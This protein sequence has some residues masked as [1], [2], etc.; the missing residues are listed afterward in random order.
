MPT[1]T[2]NPTVELLN[3]EDLLEYA[4]NNLDYAGQT[5]LLN[6]ISAELR[7]NPYVAGS[8]TTQEAW[9]N[10][11]AKKLESAGYEITYNGNGAW[12]GSVFSTKPTVTTMP[13]PIDSNVSTVSRG[14]LRNKYGG[15][16]EFGTVGQQ[17][18]VPTRFPV[19][20]GLGSKALYLVG[21]VGSGISAAS[22]GI[23]LGKTIDSALYNAFPDFWDSVGMS[24]LNPETWNS[25]TNGDDSPFAGLFN[26]ILGLDPDTGNAEAYMNE[27]TLAY[28]A[29]Y[30]KTQGVFA[31]SATSEMIDSEVDGITVNAPIPFID[32][33]TPSLV[34]INSNTQQYC[35][36]VPVGIRISTGAPVYFCCGVNERSR[37][38]SKL[39]MLRL[40]DANNTGLFAFE[41]NL[42][43]SFTA[44]LRYLDPNTG[45]YATLAGSTMTGVRT[46]N[47]K[48]I[49]ASNSLIGLTTVAY[50]Y[51][52]IMPTQPSTLRN[53]EI[54]YAALFGNYRTTGGG[55][56]GIGNQDGATLPDV[57]SW[58]DIPSTLQS[59]Q[60][61]YPDSF[62][63]PMIWNNDSPYDDTTGNMLRY[64][65]V[66]FPAIDANGNPVSDTQ[67]QT[68]TEISPQTTTQNILD[69]LMKVMQ[70]TATDTSPDDS[71][72]PQNPTDTGTGDSPTPTIP[73]GSASA[74]WSVYHPTQA[75][76]NSFGAWLWG[77]PF[78][79]DIGKLFQNPIDGVISLHKIY[80]TPVDAGS[81][82]I[83][84]GTL[85]S[86]VP[87]ATVTQ[88]YVTVN[89]GS[90]DC[91]EEFG[92]VFDYPPHTKVSLYL[93][94]IG[95]VDLDTNDVMRSTINVTYG[96]DVFTG[97][98]L[99]M[100]E[101]TRDGNTVNLYQYAGVCAVSYPLGNVQQSQLF[102]GLLA[103]AG[104]V[105]AS[106]A[107]GGVAAPAALAV[108]GGVGA[109]AKSSIGRS[110]G[111][112]GNAGA[113]GI[114]K[115]YL[116]L[117]KPQTKVA[118][119]FPRLSGYPTNKSGKLSDFS[120]Q[121]NVKSVHVEGINAT[122][123]EL[124]E[125]EA[126]LKSGVLV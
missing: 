31:T 47:D 114:K 8:L 23:W 5:E 105:A 32:L 97:A 9:A 4:A 125:I 59:L 111:F 12:T 112:S 70:Q 75:Q 15:V 7:S 104:G 81:G 19:S 60:N 108:V 39:I 64:I 18:W 103:V 6:T 124:K 78:L 61:Q 92:T 93:P 26:F 33:G 72:P 87:S 13:N 69:Y 25:I 91:H 119:T 62:A 117:Q 34:Y 110:G 20:G 54:A 94:F 115:P 89:C 27:E 2:F 55:I 77:S 21:S 121:V 101:V 35:W 82:T 48:I 42:S 79:T 76:V 36:P 49:Y 44:S 71:T 22:T 95:I 28:M 14:W 96:V 90:I 122:D 126:L 67:N 84:V 98:C 51:P 120:G 80:A 56:E 86:E 116:I 73:S 88:Q 16:N 66:P 43:T 85:D 3:F 52:E 83:V 68:S 41:S 10:E 123:V 45:Y 40:P 11:I 113:M 102:S 100:V 74:L 24:T 106:I 17:T 46:V 107:S 58:N 37:I 65:P 63:N 53:Q 30:M 1:T 29:Y 50:N 109:A 38:L 99:A 57:S 118:E